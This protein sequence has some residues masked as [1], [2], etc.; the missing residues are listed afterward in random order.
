MTARDEL[1]KYVRLLADAWTPPEQTDAR[2]ER[3][4][5]LVRTEVLR[6][7]A[8][9]LDL[10]ADEV[11]A[12]VAAHYGPASGIGPRS[13]ELVRESARTLRSMAEGKSSRRPAADATPGLT[14]R[15]ER[16]RDAIRTHGGPWTTSRVLSLYKVTDPGVV[17]RG[18]ARRDLDALHRAGHL[19]LVD[20][21][22]NRHY[23][24]RRKD[25]R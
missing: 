6:E 18:T 23:V 12:R 22:D 25:A 21:P 8:V 20:D 2:V 11:E 5:S 4:Y 13:A 24:L 19:V 7:G 14:V 9:E 15:Q 3:L 1:R 16:L 10:I 17:Q